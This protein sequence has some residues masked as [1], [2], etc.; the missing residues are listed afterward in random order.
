VV[1]L[2]VAKMVYSIGAQKGLFGEEALRKYENQEGG[3]GSAV[4]LLMA[5]RTDTFCGLYALCD[6]PVIGFG[7]WAQDTQGYWEKFLSKYGRYGEAED[8]A[9]KRRWLYSIT[10]MYP[11]IPAHSHIVGFWVAY[12]IVG[13]VLWLYVLC[14][15]VK[16][17]R[18]H[19]AAVPQWFGYIVLIMPGYIWALLFSPY[20][21]RVTDVLYVVV[22]LFARAVS[23]GRLAL[24][25]DME[26]EARQYDCRK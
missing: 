25:V 5:G 11:L 16:V 24:P 10:G 4:A 12:G 17:F 7:P 3:S 6:K 8:F 2:V 21:S 15:V 13:A 14:L 20:S 18:R 19:L 9:A 23:T 1:F 22:L 26:M